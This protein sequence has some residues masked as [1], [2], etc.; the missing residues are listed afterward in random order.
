M[1]VVLS[2]TPV[3]P[4]FLISADAAMPTITA[5]ATLSGVTVDPR[6]P[7]IYTWTATLAFNGT[8][9]GVLVPH[10]AGS[11]T[12]HRAIA[13]QT[14]PRNTFLIPFAEVRGGTLTVSVAVRVGTQTL[15]AQSTNLTIVGTNPAPSAIRTY[16]NSIG[17]NNVRFRKLMRQES[18]L[19]QFIN[20]SGAP[21]YS[22][23]DL[24]G[25]GLCQLTRPAPTADQTWN[26]KEN[27]AGGWRLYLEKQRIARAYPALVRSSA[28]FLQLVY[29]YN[30]PP[31][32]PG[33]VG[34]PRPASLT[35]TLPEYTADQLDL[36]TLRGFNGYLRQL[37]EYRVRVD[38][39]GRLVVT[40]D[41]TGRR[42]TAEW[43][44]VPIAARGGAGDPNYVNN[45]EAQADF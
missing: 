2:F 10:S 19:R 9:G 29:A 5:T 35:I 24:G 6:S 37:H 18:S 41:A 1:P 38:A 26:W 23:D 27:V 22:G 39:A 3:G 36:D 44:R 30:N 31:A 11:T 16:A 17:A 25:V 21:H 42:G 13:P 8:L 4:K 45:V 34:Q 33:A 12:T 32:V 28:A 40:P 43:E 20:A 15:T 7:P 14:G